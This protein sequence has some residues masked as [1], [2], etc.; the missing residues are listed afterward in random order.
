M[1]GEDRYSTNVPQLSGRPVM[2]AIKVPDS[3]SM[4]ADGALR[5]HDPPLLHPAKLLVV[6]ACPSVIHREVEDSNTNV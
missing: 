2:D 3:S 4:A 5:T 6:S 1:V